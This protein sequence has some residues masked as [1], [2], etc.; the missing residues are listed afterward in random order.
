MLRRC[1]I[2]VLSMFHQ[3]CINIALTLLQFYVQFPGLILYQYLVNIAQYCGNSIKPAKSLWKLWRGLSVYLKTLFKT[4]Y[5]E[6]VCIT[7]VA[8]PMTLSHFIPL[9][10]PRNAEIHQR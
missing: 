5:I 1:L 4:S 7:W 6:I 2:N 8:Y 10:I 9:E 3:Y